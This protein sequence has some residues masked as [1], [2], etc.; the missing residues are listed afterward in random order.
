MVASSPAVKLAPGVLFSALDMAICIV[1]SEMVIT[2]CGDTGVGPLQAIARTAK[3]ISRAE[4]VV[5]FFISLF[6]LVEIAL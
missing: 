2:E 5:A 4:S 6:S 1:E 3:T